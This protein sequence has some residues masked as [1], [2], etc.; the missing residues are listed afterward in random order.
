MT[1]QDF[2]RIVKKAVTPLFHGLA[3]VGSAVQA[4]RLREALQ[5]LSDGDLAALG[6]ERG[7]I[8]RYVAERMPPR[9]RRPAAPGVDVRS[10]ATTAVTH[11]AANERR[12]AA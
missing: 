8:I 10:F 12:D 1:Y 3:A 6:I 4:M 9:T 5:H 11:P 7:D 2:A